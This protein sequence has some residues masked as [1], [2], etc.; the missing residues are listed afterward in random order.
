MQISI[1]THCASV[2]DITRVLKKDPKIKIAFNVTKS[3]GINKNQL[4]Q[5]TSSEKS[6]KETKEGNNNEHTRAVGFQI[7]YR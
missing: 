3:I 5:I 2:C 4:R 6:K 7:V 1:F